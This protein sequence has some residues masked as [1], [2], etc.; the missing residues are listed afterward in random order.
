MSLYSLEKFLTKSNKYK[1]YEA[2]D[3]YFAND[4]QISWLKKTGMDRV[5]LLKNGAHLGFLYRK[6][7]Q[8]AL[9]KDILPSENKEAVPTENL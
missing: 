2:V 9:K 6:E 3:D 1:I 5:V 7:F 8:D 4:N